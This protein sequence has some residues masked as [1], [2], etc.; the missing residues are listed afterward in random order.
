MMRVKKSKPKARLLLERESATKTIQEI[1]D[2]NLDPY[3]GYRQL[4]AIYCRTS[5]M[6]D[7]LKAFFRIPGVEP[8]GVIRVDHAFREKVRDLA[9]AWLSEW[10]SRRC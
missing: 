3:L 7:E 4:Y 2:G 8:D 10:Q 6:H 5:G 1:A 9:M